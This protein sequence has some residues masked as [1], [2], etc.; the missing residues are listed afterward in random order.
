MNI[1]SRAGVKNDLKKDL[2]K[3]MNNSVFGKKKENFGKKLSCKTHNHRQKK[4]YLVSEPN[5]HTKKWF[6]ENL[7]AIEM[8]KTK[9]NMN[10]PI[11]LGLS[12]LEI[13]K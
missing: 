11:Y 8:N 3:L 13:S 4:N 10:K 2:F 9:I 1:R 12:V 5:C 7:L 6:S